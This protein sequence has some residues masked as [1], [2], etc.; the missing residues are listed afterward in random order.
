MKTFCSASLFRVTFVA[1]SIASLSSVPFASPATDELSSELT[2]TYNDVAAAGN[3]IQNAVKSLMTLS[4]GEAENLQA[5]F[6]SFTKY[7]TATESSGKAA[8]TRAKSMRDSMTDY[9]AKWTNEIDAMT[10]SSKKAEAQQKLTAVQESYSKINERLAQCAEQFVP[11]HGHL[12][13]IQGALKNDLSSDGVAAS[14]E[15]TDRATTTMLALHE[16]LKSL[17]S[18]IDETRTMLG[19]LP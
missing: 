7:V 6:Q 17:L 8:A 11:L 13:G 19:T 15:M 14:Q 4:A 18:Q 1:L 3:N 2:A 12:N 10:D 9:F 16:D 5:E